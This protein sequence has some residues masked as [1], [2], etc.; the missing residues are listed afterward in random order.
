MKKEIGSI[1]LI[2]SLILVAVILNIQTRRPTIYVT[3][4]PSHGIPPVETTA[5]KSSLIDVKQNF[6]QKNTEFRCNYNKIADLDLQ[7]VYVEGKN[8][9]NVFLVYDE[10]SNARVEDA[11]LVIEIIPISGLMFD[12][13]KN[14]EF[15]TTINGFLA[16]VND[17]AACHWENYQ[18][19]FGK[20]SIVIDIAIGEYNY[21]IRAAPTFTLS[22]AI[23]IAEKLTS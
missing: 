6:D 16:Y 7:N 8:G 17:E 3:S 21:W 23:E 12:I 10:A 2:S 1:V 22:E 18:K 19:R 20:T 14:Q 5:K 13:E 15:I 11:E 4:G 9:D